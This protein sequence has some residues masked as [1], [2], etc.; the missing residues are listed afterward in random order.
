MQVGCEEDGVAAV[1]QE[2]LECN[3]QGL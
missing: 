2:L 1:W 3:Y